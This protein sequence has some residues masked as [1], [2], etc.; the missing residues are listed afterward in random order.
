[1]KKRKLGWY[2]ALLNLTQPLVARHQ[3]MPC[4]DVMTGDKPSEASPGCPNYIGWHF[5]A[6]ASLLASF[7]HYWVRPTDNCWTSRFAHLTSG[8][9]C[10]YPWSGQTA[11]FRPQT[12]A[13]DTLQS[14]HHNRPPDIAIRSLFFCDYNYGI[15]HCW[16]RRRS[17]QSVQ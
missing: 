4:K 7:F 12:H 14:R 9:S 16:L 13:G 3:I 11:C 1:M 8:I 17:R 2:V 6:T 15:R 10:I 5:R